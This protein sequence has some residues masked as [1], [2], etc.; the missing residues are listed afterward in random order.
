MLLSVEYQQP[1]EE[2]DI[3][4]DSAGLDAL[5]NHLC[6]LKQHGGHLH[7]MTPSW[8]GTELTEIRF[9]ET[10]LLINH[11]RIAFLPNRDEQK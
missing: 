7:L 3:I 4:C 1:L 11:V 5:I 9:N 10:A 6:Q 8:A 2:L